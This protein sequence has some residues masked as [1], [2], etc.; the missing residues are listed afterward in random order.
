[1]A[2]LREPRGFFQETVRKLAEVAIDVT[3]HDDQEPEYT[4]EMQALERRFTNILRGKLRSSSP[5]GQETA[6]EG[7]E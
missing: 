5:V 6:K 4:N 7:G 3:H 1:M 2:D